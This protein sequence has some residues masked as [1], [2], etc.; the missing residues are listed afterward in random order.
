MRAGL[1]RHRSSVGS[2]CCCRCTVTSREE[3]DRAVGPA[4]R[5]VIL[6]TTSREQCHHSRASRR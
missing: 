4:G 2:F 3:Q 5:K 6:S 1:P